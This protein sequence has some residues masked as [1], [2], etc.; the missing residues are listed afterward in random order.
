MKHTN[1]LFQFFFPPSSLSSV[2]IFSLH[3]IRDEDDISI[4]QGHFFP[5]ASKGYRTSFID[6]IPV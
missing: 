1:S 2:Y 5:A 6:I 4:A 3:A